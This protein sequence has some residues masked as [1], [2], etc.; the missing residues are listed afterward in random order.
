MRQKRNDVMFGDALDF[1]DAGDIEMSLAALFPDRLCGLFGNN[2]DLGHC[3]AG[4][5]FDLEPDAKASFGF[6]ERNHLGAGI[7]R[8]HGEAFLLEKNAA[9]RVPRRCFA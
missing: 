7:T 8:Y 3:V 5:R 6:P 4:M 1:I 9:R 2:A